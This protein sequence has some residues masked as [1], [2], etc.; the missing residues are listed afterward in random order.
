MYDLEKLYEYTELHRAIGEALIFRNPSVDFWNKPEIA[1]YFP[2]FR[3][4]DLKDFYSQFQAVM[5]LSRT[6]YI[7]QKE[8]ERILTELRVL[9]DEL[10]R[11]EPPKKGTRLTRLLSTIEELKYRVPNKEEFKG[12]AL[13]LENDMEADGKDRLRLI[14][15]GY[16]SIII[17]LEEKSLLAQMLLEAILDGRAQ[18]FSAQM[19]NEQGQENQ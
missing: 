5:D 19:V 7:Q 8:I 1:Q 12:K 2:L 13:A 17:V 15:E 14:E 3:V 10:L 6:P 4:A 11:E 16:A 18:H 9:K